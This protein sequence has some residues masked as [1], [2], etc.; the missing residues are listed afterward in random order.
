M[1]EARIRPAL[2]DDAAEMA[3]VQLAGWRTAYRGIF[4]DDVLDAAE[5]A[6]D[7]WHQRLAV[8]GAVAFVGATAEG[9]VAIAA[10]GPPGK[11]PRLDF[12][13]EIYS[14]Y[15]LPEWRRRGLGRQL[16]AAAFSAFLRNGAGGAYLW[17]L[18]GNHDGRSFYARLS[19]TEVDSAERPSVGGLVRRSVAIAWPRDAMAGVCNDRALD[20]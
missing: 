20:R 13:A 19:G 12:G 1:R 10:G 6:T 5:P 14:L 8:P 16:V 18:A 17:C 7:K 2:L 15:L 9:I 11:E 4:P 3:R